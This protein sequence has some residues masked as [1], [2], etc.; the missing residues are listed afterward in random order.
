MGETHFGKLFVELCFLKNCCVV[1][2]LHMTIYERAS[3]LILHMGKCMNI[4][5]GKEK[6][7]EIPLIMEFMDLWYYLETLKMFFPTCIIWEID[8]KSF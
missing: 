3:C 8:R 1:T 5:H 7:L 6:H 2:L 4:W